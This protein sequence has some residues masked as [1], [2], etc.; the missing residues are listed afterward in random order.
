MISFHFHNTSVVLD[1]YKAS[2]SLMKL[3]DLEGYQLNEVSV[4]FCSDEYLLDL[5]NTFLLHDYF[6]DILTFDYSENNKLCGELYVSVE[7]IIDNSKE[8]NVS[9]NQ[10]LTRVVIHGFLHMCGYNDKTVEQKTEMSSKE[11]YYLS[12]FGVF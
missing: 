9:I 12:Y 6:T 5:N 11:D 7:R 10:E 3:I 8:F 2:E 4:V 1:E